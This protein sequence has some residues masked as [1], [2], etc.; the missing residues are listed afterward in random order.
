MLQCLVVGVMSSIFYLSCPSTPHFSPLSLGLCLRFIPSNSG[1]P[2]AKKLF[3]TSCVSIFLH[4]L[5]LHLLPRPPCFSLTHSYCVLIFPPHA[6]VSC[7]SLASS[8]CS[9]SFYVFTHLVLLLSVLFCFPLSSV[10]SFSLYSHHL[11]LSFLTYV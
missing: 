3:P 7:F 6:P 2:A 8:L 1:V 10:S 9:S 11:N 5:T 4:P